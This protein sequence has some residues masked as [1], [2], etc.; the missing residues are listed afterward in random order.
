MDF[1]TDEERLATAGIY[2][3]LWGAARSA[4]ASMMQDLEM[5]RK[6]EIDAI[7]GMLSKKGK[8]FGIPAPVND[9]VVEIVK[10]IEDGR[11]TPSLENL[12]MFTEC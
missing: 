3:E 5:G 11:Y 2:K 10:G 9:K 7:N 12:S 4:K 8:E 6:S 1:E